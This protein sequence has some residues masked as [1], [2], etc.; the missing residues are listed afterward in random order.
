MAKNITELTIFVAAP[1]DVDAEVEHLRDVIDNLNYI[2]G[3]QFG[4]KLRMVHWRTSAYPA[5]GSDPQAVINEQI[6]EDF[7]VFVGILWKSFGQPTPRAPSGTLEEFERAYSR[8]QASPDEIQILFYFK[9]LPPSRLSDIDP[10]SLAKINEFRDSWRDRGLYCIF[11]DSQEFAGLAQRH[12]GK[13]QV[14]W[15]KTW[16]RGAPSS[17]VPQG[18]PSAVQPSERELLIQPAYLDFFDDYEENLESA[19]AIFARWN[20]ATESLHSDLQQRIASADK[21]LQAVQR[22]HEAVAVV[23]FVMRPVQRLASTLRHNMPAFSNAHQTAKRNLGL[24]TQDLLENYDESDRSHLERVL[25][26]IRKIEQDYSG[27]LEKL[28]E[29]VDTMQSFGDQFTSVRRSRRAFL[30]QLR[31]VRTEMRGFLSSLRSA[32]AVIERVIG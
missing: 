3:E 27:G 8:W 29:L 13:L 16:G 31:V 1:S 2:F 24:A 18:L 12:L 21:R 7:D 23:D 22:E 32:A 30:K 9:D 28:Q 10:D 4:V 15:G 25:R 19:L 5:V 11:S 20:D 14:N 17:D 26:T 6:G